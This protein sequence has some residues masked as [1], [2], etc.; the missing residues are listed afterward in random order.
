MKLEAGKTYV[1]VSGNLWGEWNGDSLKV[2]DSK[3]SLRIG[4]KMYFEK[5]GE[6]RG[7]PEF[8]ISHEYVETETEPDPQPET[9]PFK[10]ELGERYFT[11]D[12]RL[13]EP[14]SL[15]N[16][17]GKYKFFAV[18]GGGDVEVYTKKGKYH[19]DYKEHDLDLVRKAVRGV[20][21]DVEEMNNNPTTESILDLAK[22]AVGDR[23]L[24]YGKPEENFD[25]IANLWNAYLLNKQDKALYAEDV[26][27]MMILLKVARLQNCP[28]HKDSIVDVAG[29]AACLGEMINEG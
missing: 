11:R 23:G 12:G 21:Y 27:C 2:K 15:R 9:P 6:C 19:A 14:V 22:Q 3:T 16:S 29:Y 20:D 13:S 17:P 7:C 18:I 4:T 24:N 26:A 5:K 8:N 1:D 10:L 25:R 28:H